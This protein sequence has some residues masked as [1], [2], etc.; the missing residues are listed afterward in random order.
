MLGCRSLWQDWA[1]SQW[2]HQVNEY[3]WNMSFFYFMQCASEQPMLCITMRILIIS[4]SQYDFVSFSNEKYLYT[5]TSTSILW[6]TGK[7]VT[8]RTMLESQYDHSTNS[9]RTTKWLQWQTSYIM[10]Q[11]CKCNALL[12]FLQK[13]PYNAYNMSNKL[14]NTPYSKYIIIIN[15]HDISPSQWHTRQKMY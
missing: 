2:T 7:T 3:S 13:R 8:T 4:I 1:E 6:T 10:A 15:T 11:C 5:A 14:E 9:K 12:W